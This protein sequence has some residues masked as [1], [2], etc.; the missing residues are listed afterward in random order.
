MKIYSK[1]LMMKMT[2]ILFFI[3]VGINSSISQSDELLKTRI[4]LICVQSIDSPIQLVAK[5]RAKEGKSYLAVKDE[6]I[7]FFIVTEEDEIS[8]GDNVTNSSGEAAVIITDN[9]LLSAD[10][11]GYY[12]VSA[13]YNGSDKYEDDSE[14]FYFKI[15]SINMETSE[16]EDV[17]SIDVR[18]YETIDGEEIPIEDLEITLSVPMMFSNLS[19][20]SEYSDEDGMVAFEFPNDLPGDKTGNVRIIA[21]VLESDDYG[22]LRQEL[23]KDWGIPKTEVIE[24]TRSLWSPDAPLWMVISFSILMFTVWG[25]FIYIIYRLFQLKKEGQVAVT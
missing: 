15:A 25:H 21:E 24:Q 3:S 5:L 17:K 22:N 11:D 18:V 19:I 2:L 12:T 14:E 20:G 1:I 16:D 6:Q 7:D 4:D 10:E 13:S 23:E 8:I 9:S